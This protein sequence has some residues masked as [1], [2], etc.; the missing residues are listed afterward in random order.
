M[1]SLEAKHRVA[2]ST[3][4]ALAVVSVF[5]L[6]TFAASN[7]NHSPAG[8][9]AISRLG[10]LRLD[11]P[12]GKL[13]GTGRMIIDGEEAPS[14][15]TV[16]SGS[17]I[18]TGPDGNA[19]IDLGSLG[20]IELRPNTTITLVFS[21]VSVQVDMS[22]GGAMAQ[23]VPSG[24]EGQVRTSS[25]QVRF[26][27]TRGQ[28]EVKSARSTRKLFAGEAGTFADQAEAFASGDTLLVAEYGG[29]RDKAGAVS[30]SGRST[31]AGLGGAVA[32]AGIAGGVALGVMAGR[33]DRTISTLPKP[34]TVVP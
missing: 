23:W 7:I 4:L 2:I 3:V 24:V 12:V 34:S 5:T 8:V 17:K 32:L 22:G 27:V 26:L 33:N 11:V 31:S 6:S 30:H 15:A 19:T 29:S 10:K 1:K 25:P 14:G 9:K 13:I 21:S 28:I 16:L 18:A 20:R